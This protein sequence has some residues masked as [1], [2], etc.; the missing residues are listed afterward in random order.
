MKKK[1]MIKKSLKKRSPKKKSDPLAL[2]AE[3]PQST[4]KKVTEVVLS[5]KKLLP[6]GK[7]LKSRKLP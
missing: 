1:I 7:T 3:T 4:E 5:K 2:K 6:E